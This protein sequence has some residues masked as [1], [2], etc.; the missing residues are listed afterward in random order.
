MADERLGR[1]LGYLGLRQ[2]RAAA[3]NSVEYLSNAKRLL[4]ESEGMDG[5]LLGR[6][7]W[8]AVV[9]DTVFVRTKAESPVVRHV[10]RRPV[11]RA[12]ACTMRGV[13]FG[14]YIECT[15]RI[16]PPE[17]EAEAKGALRR[18]CGPILRLRD[19][20]ARGD[21]VYLEL[22]PVGRKNTP[23]LEAKVVPL[24]ATLMEADNRE[25]PPGA[26]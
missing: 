3:S 6:T 21:Y 12:A 13:P 15:A 17:G 25:K 22:T 24:R 18:S 10:R 9:D 26:A 11:V 2:Q 8:F 14:D 23:S 1:R 7:M 4:L 5:T 16:T 20:F 19:S